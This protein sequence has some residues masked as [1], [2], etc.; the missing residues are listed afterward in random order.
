PPYIAALHGFYD[1]E[2]VSVELFTDR[3]VV[4]KDVLL[5]VSSKFSYRMHIDFD[6]ANAADVKGFTLGRII[7]QR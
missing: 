5:R 6:E 4:F 2:R 1:K 7:R 3:P